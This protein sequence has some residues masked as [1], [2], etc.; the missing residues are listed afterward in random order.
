MVVLVVGPQGGASAS[1]QRGDGLDVQKAHAGRLGQLEAGLA[2]EEGSR[3]VD[4]AGLG[5]SREDIRCG[6]VPGGGQR[7]RR[8]FRRD[9][10]D[11]QSQAGNRA[12]CVRHTSGAVWGFA[13]ALIGRF[14][15][16]VLSR[17]ATMAVN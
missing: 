8:P 6:E 1:D 7:R 17:S 10:Q 11:G 9:G 2:V 13:R 5:H 14:A 4:V 12:G 15:D 3:R 16:T